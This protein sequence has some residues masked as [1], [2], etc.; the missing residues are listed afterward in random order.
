M[1]HFPVSTARKLIKPNIHKYT[2]LQFLTNENISLHK[3][4]NR[5]K[6]FLKEVTMPSNSQFSGGAHPVFFILY[7]II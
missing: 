6:K 7:A 1:F 2:S 4:K 3:V 5:K